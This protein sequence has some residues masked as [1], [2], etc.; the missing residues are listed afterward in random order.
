MEDGRFSLLFR[1]E[2][3]RVEIDILEKKGCFQES[4]N[5]KFIL[6]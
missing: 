3:D 1:P 2:V 6:V 5:R 4:K